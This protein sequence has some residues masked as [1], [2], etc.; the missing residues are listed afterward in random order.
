MNR[1]F[2]NS[3]VDK[4]IVLIV[5][6]VCAVLVVG[7]IFLT[8]R[9]SNSNPQVVADTK[10]EQN[11]VSSDWSKGNANAPVTLVE[12]GDFQCPACAAYH[13]VVRQI[14]SE[15]PDKVRFVYRHFPLTNIHNKAWNAAKAS[16]AAGKQGKFWEMYDLLFV[17]Q[18]K[19]EGQ[20]ISEFNK[21]HEGYASQLGLN[22]E[23][24][25]KDFSS[26]EV[27]QLVKDD[28][29][30]G[31]KFGVRG[32]PSFYIN[33]VYTELPGSYERFK[34]IIEGEAAKAPAPQSNGETI[35]KHADFA[36]FANG[37]KVNLSDAKF[38][39]KHPDI[40][41][42]DANGDI[43][44]AHKDKVTL[45]TFYNALGLAIKPNVLYVNNTKF[46]ANWGDYVF[47]DLDRLVLS[48]SELSPKQ[49]AMV[50][51]KACIYSETCPDRGKPPTENCVGGLD[52]PCV[53][54][55]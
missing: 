47:K 19:W 42:H 51:D 40:H 46:D 25:K 4:K 23:Q 39:E 31:N 30:L 35:H 36:L 17:N 18:T 48:T 45:G 7:G 32:T 20:S 29:V 5:T 14:T 38:D 12:Y 11:V 43:I 10:T 49:L 33:G 26:L 34:A 22:L 9:P 16:E 6:A 27:E 3:G 55:E 8:S 21:T 15:I 50:T 1:L 54:E 37:N 28:Q 52:T 2:D 24:Y 53:V 13:S 41:F 44:H